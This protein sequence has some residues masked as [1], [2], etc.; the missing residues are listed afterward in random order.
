MHLS[1]ADFSVSFRLKGESCNTFDITM[2]TRSY[3]LRSC[4]PAAPFSVRPWPYREDNAIWNRKHWTAQN[5]L[6]DR[7][8]TRRQNDDNMRTV[9]GDR[10]GHMA[11]S[12]KE[13]LKTESFSSQSGVHNDWGSFG[14][15]AVPSGTYSP[16][17]RETVRQGWRTYGSRDQ[18]GTRNSLLSC[19]FIYFAKSAPLFCQEYVDTL[20]YPRTDCIWIAVATNY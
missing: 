11:E 16:T 19:F 2:F 12:R 10:T 9:H 15:S 7:L 5:S 4:R 8:W 14:C 6:H 17:F 20:T 13:V 1:S 18:N 3:D